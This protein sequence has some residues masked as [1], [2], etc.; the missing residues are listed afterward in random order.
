M[1]DVQL[2]RLDSGGTEVTLVKKVESK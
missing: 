1:D 2:R